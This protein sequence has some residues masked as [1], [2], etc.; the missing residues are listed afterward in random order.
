MTSIDHVTMDSCTDVV[1]D[2]QGHRQQW[3]LARS[4]PAGKHNQPR[5]Q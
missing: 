5:Q 1:F 4:C 3:G 2:R